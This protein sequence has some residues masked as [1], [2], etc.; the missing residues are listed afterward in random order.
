MSLNLRNIYHVTITPNSVHDKFVDLAR[1][2]SYKINVVSLNGQ[3]FFTM[4]M[5]DSEQKE[6]KE[7]CKFHGIYYKITQIELREFYTKH[8]SNQNE[9]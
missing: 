5:F 9:V 2:M 6:F 8:H 3:Y 7:I 4:E 1:A